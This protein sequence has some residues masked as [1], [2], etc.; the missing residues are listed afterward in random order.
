MNIIIIIY[1]GYE[2]GCMGMGVRE[3]M[4]GNGG[5]RMDV[6]EWGYENCNKGSMGMELGLFH[7][8]YE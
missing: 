8:M 3:W 6:W 4:Y 2:N 1:I 5:M 7:L